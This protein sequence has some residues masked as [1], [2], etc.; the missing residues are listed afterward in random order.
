MKVKLRFVHYATKL[1]IQ[2]TNYSKRNIRIYVNIVIE[3]NMNLK[4]ASRMTNRPTGE[5]GEMMK[6]IVKLVE[7]ER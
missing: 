5:I 1:L 7:G 6:V 3:K 4:L 2:A